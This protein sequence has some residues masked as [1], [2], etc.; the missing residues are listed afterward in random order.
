MFTGI[1][2]ETGEIVEKN[3]SR[4]GITF[5]FRVGALYHDLDIG[6]S[7]SVNG[8]CLTVTAK[9]QGCIEVDASPETIRR[10]NL[11]DTVIGDPVNLEPPL[12]L[13]D[14]LGG[15]LV[16]GHVDA[17]GEVLEI[18]TDGNSWVFKIALPEEVSRYCVMKGSITL[19]GISLT[20]S[21]LGD[22]F[23]E[24]TII[25]HTMEVTNMSE[26]KPGDKVNLEVDVISKYV[27]KHTKSSMG[28]A[29]VDNAWESGSSE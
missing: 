14:V 13:N 2:R 3:E 5:R 8:V 25:P 26:L 24:V 17:T 10:S 12:K 22:D 7:I 19:E 23:M 6:H 16:Q 18:R 28:F 9:D 27:E 21:A 20:I 11:G 4:D 15:H 29:A 1:V